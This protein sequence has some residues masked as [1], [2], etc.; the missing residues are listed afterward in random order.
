MI[1]WFYKHCHFVFIKKIKLNVGKNAVGR[2]MNSPWE[3]LCKSFCQDKTFLWE[4]SVLLQ[5]NR[6]DI[7]HCIPLIVQ[8]SEIINFQ[9]I[10]VLCNENINFLFSWDGILGFPE[11]IQTLSFP[12]AQKETMLSRKE[13]TDAQTDK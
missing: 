4:V 10:C 6:S 12:K 13:R 5:A 8:F 7:L 9:F 2:K 3:K 1:L 11:V